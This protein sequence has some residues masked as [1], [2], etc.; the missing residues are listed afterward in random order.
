MTQN[1]GPGQVC[2][3]LTIQ[4]QFV[5]I[6]PGVLNHPKVPDIS[7]LDEFQGHVFHTARWDYGYTGGSLRD[8]VLTDLKDKRV[9][10]IGTGATAIQA[11][12][13]LAKWEKE[14]Y[15]F[16]RTP[17]RVDIR[18]QMATD[19]ALW[20][21]KIAGKPWWQLAQR[22]NFNAV[23]AG[24]LV[25]EDLVADGWCAT[26]SAAASLGSP[27][28]GIISPERVKDHGA[29]VY[30]IDQESS[31]RTPG[32]HDEYLASFNQS[33]VHLVDT[34][35]KGIERLNWRGLIANG[36]QYDIELLLFGTGYRA[37]A[38]HSGSPA[39][40]AKIT[41]AGWEGRSLEAKY[42]SCGVSTLHGISSHGFPNLF[43][44]GTS[45]AASAF[46]IVCMADV[47]VQHIAYILTEATR[48]HDHAVVEVTKE[49]VKEWAA[50]IAKRGA[51]SAVMLGCT[52]SWL[53]GEGAGS[54]AN[55]DVR[56]Q[57][58]KARSAP[59]GEGFR[60]YEDVLECW[61]AQGDLRG[62]GISG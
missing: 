25:D 49:A 3:K 41:I 24:A 44:F 45:Q 57:V 59:W 62:I 52:P 14:L 1:R 8:P 58:K 29:E 17:A 2:I 31:E 50:K 33:N 20:I 10:I 56:E 42:L 47:Q 48:Q 28:K 39:V 54:K 30:A 13:Q 16:Q 27:V 35:G 51:W 18:N 53:N 12:P 38:A 40:A 34:D 19:E 37:P 46:N 23:R 15:V 60:S 5:I 7:G 21:S 9:G 6:A 55:S 22:Q 61:R 26:P 11:V 36:K 32:F 43:Y 4:A